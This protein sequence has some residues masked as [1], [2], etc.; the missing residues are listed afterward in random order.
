LDAKASA[1]PARQ[2]RRH[3]YAEL[4]EIRSRRATS[5]GV[6]P[7]ANHAAARIRTASRLP[8]ARADKPPPSQYLMISE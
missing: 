5:S 6:T 3:T 1:P 7:S 2:R 4:F 8:R